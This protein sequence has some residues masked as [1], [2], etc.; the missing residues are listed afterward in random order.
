MPLAHSLDPVNI[1]SFSP[2]PATDSEQP[3]I[4]LKERG[5]IFGVLEEIRELKSKPEADSEAVVLAVMSGM[6]A[7]VPESLLPKLWELQ[8]QYISILRASKERWS[9]ALCSL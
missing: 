4:Y 5:I 3:V 7:E 2:S 1:K 6:I 8:G 9:A